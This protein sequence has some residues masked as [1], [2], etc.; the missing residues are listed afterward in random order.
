MHHSRPGSRMELSFPEA[1]GEIL[2][3][4]WNFSLG[5][6]MGLLGQ[7]LAWEGLSIFWR[8]LGF[9]PCLLVCAKCTWH[10]YTVTFAA[11]QLMARVLGVHRK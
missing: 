9:L 6:C 5:L 11:D 1:S 10:L 8:D 3:A 4:A 7:V 2:P